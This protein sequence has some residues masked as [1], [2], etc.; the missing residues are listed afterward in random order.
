[1]RLDGPGQEQGQGRAGR[2]RVAGC[3]T[4]G[5]AEELGAGGAG[6]WRLVSGPSLPAADRNAH[7]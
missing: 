3:W 1:M 6:S 4:A 5:S 2:D 7:N